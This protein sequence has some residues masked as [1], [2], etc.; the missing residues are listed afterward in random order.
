MWTKVHGERVVLLLLLK[1]ILIGLNQS[2][3]N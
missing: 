1:W 2:K 3:M